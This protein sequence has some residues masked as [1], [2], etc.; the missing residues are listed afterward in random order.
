MTLAWRMVA[1]LEYV[2]FIC[3]PFLLLLLLLLL[4][5]HRKIL[6]SDSAIISI[7]SCELCIRIAI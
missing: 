7:M 2:L 4:L 6:L 3:I 5:V 1:Q